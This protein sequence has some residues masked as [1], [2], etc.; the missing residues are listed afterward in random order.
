MQISDLS[1]VYN[2]VVKSIFPHLWIVDNG[3]DNKIWVCV[4]KLSHL[5]FQVLLTQVSSCNLK[6]EQNLDFVS[7]T[8]VDL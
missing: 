1:K 3:G 8:N 2:S 6:W 4:D 5:G 7:V